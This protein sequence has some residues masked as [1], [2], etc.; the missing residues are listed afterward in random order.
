MI[1][2]TVRASSSRTD[3]R[4]TRIVILNVMTI[5]GETDKNTK[6]SFQPVTSAK[7]MAP[8]VRA[9]REMNSGIFS[10]RNART[11]RDVCQPSHFNSLD[12]IFDLV[13]IVD[14]SAAQLAG[15]VHVEPADL[16]PDD[17][18][19]ERIAHTSDLPLGGNDPTRPRNPIEDDTDKTENDVILDDALNDITR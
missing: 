6:A 15:I 14:Q 11:D 1:Y 9:R 3:D 19:K 10:L 12:S 4:L 5:N 18:S 7:T 13:Q 16:L 17:V 2:T 8:I